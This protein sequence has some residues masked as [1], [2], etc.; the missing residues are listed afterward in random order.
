MATLLAQLFNNPDFAQFE[1][2]S[3]GYLKDP[4]NKSNRKTITGLKKP[5]PDRI[6]RYQ[7]K[8]LNLFFIG[9]RNVTL[10]FVLAWG[11]I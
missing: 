10:L 1:Y 3:Q 7:T 4:E 9:F 11:L 8:N 2:L 5:M 6:K